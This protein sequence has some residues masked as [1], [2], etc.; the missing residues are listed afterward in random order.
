MTVLLTTI[1]DL[2]GYE[3]C[4]VKDYSE[5]ENLYPALIILDAG[6]IEEL[7]G[8]K[9]CQKIRQNTNFDRTKLIVT[10]VLHDKELILTAGADLYIPKP[11]EISNL[12]KWVEKLL[13]S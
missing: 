1:L 4:V 7:K 13:N 11:Y 2:Q 6:N 10:S 9:L 12:I 5:I 3:V 8:L